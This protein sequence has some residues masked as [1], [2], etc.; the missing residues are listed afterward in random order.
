MDGQ[1]NNLRQEVNT[2]HSRLYEIVQ[3]AFESLGVKL[4]W[5]PDKPDTYWSSAHRTPQAVIEVQSLCPRRHRSNQGHFGTGHQQRRTRFHLVGEMRPL[6]R[7]VLFLG[8]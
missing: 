1:I 7:S 3:A 8:V 6:G 2:I 4:L 5:N